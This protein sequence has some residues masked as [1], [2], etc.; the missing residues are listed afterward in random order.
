M[1]EA[2]T[3]RLESA[4]VIAVVALD[5]AD[6]SI[7]L[8]HALL[9]GGVT[10]IELTLRTH[11][12]IESIRR[13]VKAVPEMLVGAGTV[14]TPGQVRQVKD[15]GAAFGVSPGF[16]PTVVE[17]AKAADLSFA[18]GICTPSELEAAQELG[19]QVLKFFPAESS[20]GLP[21]LKSM[22]APYAHLGLKF[23]PLGGLTADNARSYIE[24]KNVLAIG[25]S[26]IA[27][28]DDIRNENWN[29]ITEQAKQA[30]EN[31]RGAGETNT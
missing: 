10:A 22:T 27:P 23:I 13:C 4:G 7:P 12:G 8:A 30:V 24:Q 18:P 20:G 29:L 6:R 1:N 21:F 3:N 16:N 25:G 11:A 19:C 15:A 17:A 14:L 31:L 26:W 5:S 2:L 28:A 9:E